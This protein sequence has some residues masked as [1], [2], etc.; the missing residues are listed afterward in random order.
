M[1]DIQAHS[2]IQSFS[3]SVIQSF[4]HSVIQSFSH[5]VIQAFRH[6]GRLDKKTIIPDTGT[7]NIQF[8]ES[9]YDPIDSIVTDMW[10]VVNLYP[11]KERIYKKESSS[12]TYLMTVLYL[13]STGTERA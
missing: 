9:N 4:S 7:Y 3:H 12:L 11:S 1:A 6:S 10:Q 13:A 2:V 5:S 8:S